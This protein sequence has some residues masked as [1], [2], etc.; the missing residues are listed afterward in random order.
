MVGQLL[1]S[2]DPTSPVT[3]PSLV[4]RLRKGPVE[5]PRVILTVPVC[6]AEPMVTPFDRY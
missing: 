6:P 5:L 3:L 1:L 4:P 2:D